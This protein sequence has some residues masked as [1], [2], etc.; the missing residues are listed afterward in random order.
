ME[1]TVAHLVKELKKISQEI[2]T[3]QDLANVASVSAGAHTHSC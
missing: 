3:D 1:K 2:R